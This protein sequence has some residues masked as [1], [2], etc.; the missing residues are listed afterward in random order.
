MDGFCKLKHRLSIWIYNPKSIFIEDDRRYDRGRY[1]KHHDIRSKR[2]FSFI[3]ELIK[4]A[5]GIELTEEEKKK[6]AFYIYEV[7]QIPKGLYYELRYF[8]NEDKIFCYKWGNC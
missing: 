7:E 2:P 6:L 8:E 1:A 5:K 3:D 4:L